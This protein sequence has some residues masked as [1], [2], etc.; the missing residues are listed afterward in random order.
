MW[1]QTLV[2]MMWQVLFAFILSCPAFATTTTAPTLSCAVN[3]GAVDI[4][5]ARAV[6]QAVRSFR[7][8]GKKE[9][10]RVGEL[11]L[12]LQKKS[13]ELEEPSRPIHKAADDLETFSDD[14][15]KLSTRTQSEFKTKVQRLERYFGILKN[16]LLTIESV[17]REINKLRKEFVAL[18]SQGPE[19]I[20]SLTHSLNQLSE[21]SARKTFEPEHVRLESTLADIRMGIHVLD[22]IEGVWDLD[23]KSYSDLAARIE[24]ALAVTVPLHGVASLSDLADEQASRLKSANDTVQ[25]GFDEALGGLASQLGQPQLSTSR[26]SAKIAELANQRKQIQVWLKSESTKAQTNLQSALARLNHR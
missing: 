22:K 1:R 10:D 9:M 18:Q 5:D 15:L 21:P 25:N 6:A 23:R 20:A 12:R 8:F 11:N 19:M 14:L 4:S 13:A 2:I 24:E 26:T 3:L 7:E 16:D 17:L